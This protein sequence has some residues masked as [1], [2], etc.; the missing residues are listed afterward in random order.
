[1]STGP[2]WIGIDAGK[3]NHH[4]TAINTVGEVLWSKQVR[5]DQATIETL[6][7]KAT[8]SGAQVLWAVDLTNSYAALLLGVLGAADQTVVYVPGRMVNT[9]TATF[10]ESKTDAKDAL[11][12]AQT[13]RMR[14]D[15]ATV[16]TPPE[17]VAELSR[18]TA[19][20]TDLAADWVRGVNRLRDLLGSIFPGLERAL[21][22]TKRSPLILLTGFATP[23]EIRTAGEE[24][25]VSHLRDHGAHRPSI[26]KIAAAASE[27]AQA[28]S[29]V[30]PGQ[31]STATLIKRLAAK[32]LELDRERKDLDKTITGVFRSNP[33]AEII[34]SLPGMGPILGAEF[35]TVTGGDLAAF[36]HSGRLASYAGLAPVSKDSGRVSGNLRRPKRYN[37][38]LRRVFYMAA[39]SSIKADGPSRVFYR[40]KRSER[41]LHKQALLALARRLVNVLW[42]LLRD[43]RL[44]ERSAPVRPVAA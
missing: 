32:L 39:L 26:A 27:A 20:R 4:A 41:M 6:I 37:R 7:N 44:F 30:L 23:E 11:V 13:A 38:R 8:A 42:A 12:I 25:I 19:H 10:G 2:M 17:L 5:N 14:P 35:I 3:T 16:T 31:N 24:E 34:E 1:M 21:D 43:G 28:Q 40:K 15:L 29:I 33:Q 22:Y 9:M 36:A 18:L